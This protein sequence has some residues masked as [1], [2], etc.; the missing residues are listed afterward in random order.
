MKVERF[1]LKDLWLPTN[2]PG[3][4]WGVPTRGDVMM[5]FDL[6]KKNQ[7]FRVKTIKHVVEG[8]RYSLEPITTL[9]AESRKM[10]GFC[11]FTVRIVEDAGYPLVE[12]FRMEEDW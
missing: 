12:F 11:C 2:A 9:A 5:V 8:T 6:K 3:K 4:S 1:I 7:Y 10:N